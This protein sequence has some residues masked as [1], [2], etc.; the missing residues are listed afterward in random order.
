MSIP[1]LSKD[2][3][4]CDKHTGKEI[5][6]YEGYCLV[7]NSQEILTYRTWFTDDGKREWLFVC[8]GL[9]SNE[10]GSKYQEGI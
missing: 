7:M 3:R 5:L 8:H 6:D 9:P 2:G 1:F 4:I 10:I